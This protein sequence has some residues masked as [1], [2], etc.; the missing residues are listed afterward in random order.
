MNF[1]E[2][3]LIQILNSSN[4]TKSRLFEILTTDLKKQRQQTS[5][6]TQPDS[7]NLSQL[8]YLLVVICLYSLGALC[9][10]ISRV[11][12][13]S[14]YAFHQ[15]PIAKNAHYLLNQMKDKTLLE[16]LRD[17]DY[18]KRVWSIYRKDSEGKDQRGSI[19]YFKNEDIILK[20]INKKLKTIEKEKDTA[21]EMR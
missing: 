5:E 18:R 15:Y 4:I 19:F 10:L 11:K 14:K 12:P 6:H 8:I 17:K 20:S 2:I 21:F 1:D 9:V 3:S 7:D 13:N 16:Q